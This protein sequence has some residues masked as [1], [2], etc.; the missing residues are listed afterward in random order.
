M[1]GFRPC[2]RDS[3]CVKA[4]NFNRK[5]KPKY[6]HYEGFH[7]GTN[8]PCATAVIPPCAALYTHRC[9]PRSA[10]SA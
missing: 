4:I 8:L 9:A 1:Q 2:G 5:I 3:P 10:S 6:A 7:Q